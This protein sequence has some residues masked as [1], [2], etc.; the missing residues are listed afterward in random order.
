MPTAWATYRSNDII[1]RLVVV[2]VPLK[3]DLI[4]AIDSDRF[5]SLDAGDVALH[6]LGSN[7]GHWIVVWGRV[8]VSTLGVADTLIL[9]I[10]ENIPDGGMGSG[11]LSA[12]SKSKS[13]N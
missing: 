9:S 10:D 8:D 13:D 7:I 2:V 1:A 3:S 11:K 5:R 4:T 6:S 12:A